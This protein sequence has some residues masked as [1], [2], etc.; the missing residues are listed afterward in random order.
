LKLAYAL[1]VLGVIG[2]ILSV[3]MAIGPLAG[4]I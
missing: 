3:T 1:A 4:L 2:I